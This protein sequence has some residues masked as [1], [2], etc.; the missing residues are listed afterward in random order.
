MLVPNDLCEVTIVAPKLP[1]YLKLHVENPAPSRPRHE[2]VPGLARLRDTFR[3]ATGVELMS[4]PSGSASVTEASAGEWEALAGAIGQIVQQLDDTRKALWHREAELAAGVPVT[5]H[6]DEQ[7]HL[8]VR[9]EAVL[10]AGAQAIGC[11]AV[12]MYMLD[13]TSKH[14]KLRSCWGLPKSRFLDA[15]R[16][17]RGAV[18]D[19]EALVGHAVML[20]DTLL[21]SDWSV[22]E[23]FRSAIC[24]PI[25]TPTTLLGTLWMFCDRPRTF[26]KDESNLMEIVS[27]RLAADLEREMLL[28]QAM[29]VRS[30]RRQLRHAGRWQDQRLPR[31]KPLLHG[32]EI[33]GKTIQGDYLGGDFHD[34]F[35]LP[36]GTLG[37]VVGDAQGRLVEAGLTSAA[38]H[39]T[40]KAHANYRHS[41]Q[42]LV[43]RTN[44]TLWSASAGDQFAAL[45][46]AKIQPASGRIECASAGP[47]DASIVGPQARPLATVDDSPLGMQPD[48]VYPLQREQMQVG[49]S[50]VVFSQGFKRSLKVGKAKLLWRLVQRHHAISA[51]GL[52][53]RIEAFAGQ[54]CREQVSED[55]TWLV[56]KRT[57][58]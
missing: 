14:L 52:V 34:W 42:Q 57:V 4:V 17:L 6:P 5:I 40:V 3:R 51:N 18:A 35:V 29:D 32:W 53:D 21:M 45:F 33:A 39:S 50:L 25:S 2:E 47:I 36:D 38:L 13:E 41:A 16:P 27:G 22:P 28:H 44:E 19:L 37:I 20:E 31:I 30:I 11:Q 23:E 1:G 48:A 49:D 46:Y 58:V 56:I 54:H 26:S 7:H 43:E 24:V 12:A 8:A 15:P 55:R 10:K 9:L